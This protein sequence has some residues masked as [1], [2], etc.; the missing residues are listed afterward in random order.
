VRAQAKR[1]E[2]EGHHIKPSK[3][4]KPPVVA[5]YGRALVRL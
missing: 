1:L 3:G 2:D 4:K 5:N